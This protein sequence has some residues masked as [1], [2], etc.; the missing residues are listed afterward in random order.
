MTYLFIDLLK[1]TPNSRI[2]NVSSLAHQGITIDEKMRLNDLSNNIKFFKDH[3]IHWDDINWEKSYDAMKAYGQSKTA[4]ILFT[5]ELA[6]R[7][8]GDYNNNRT[9]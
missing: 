6:K 1:K 4:N 7:L 9:Q 5:R 2:I 8:K 3:D